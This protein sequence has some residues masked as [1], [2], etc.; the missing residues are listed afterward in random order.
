M[1]RRYLQQN[2]LV[3]FSSHCWQDLSHSHPPALSLCSA[4]GPSLNEEAQSGD[5]THFTDRETEA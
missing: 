3:L 4:K 2:F 1:D 5:K